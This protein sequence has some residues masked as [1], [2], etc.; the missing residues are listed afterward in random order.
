VAIAVWRAQDI[1]AIVGTEQRQR[2]LWRKL[3]QACERK[4]FARPGILTRLIV[5]IVIPERCRYV[6]IQLIDERNNVRKFYGVGPSIQSVQKKLEFHGLTVCQIT[7]DGS[8][9]A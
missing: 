1:G 4:H 9:Y 7:F 6:R 3:L 5:D 2:L 8:S